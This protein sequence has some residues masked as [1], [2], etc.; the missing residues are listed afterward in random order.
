MNRVILTARQRPPV[1]AA[2]EALFQLASGAATPHLRSRRAATVGGCDRQALESAGEFAW[3]AECTFLVS[4]WDAM[5][6]ALAV[7]GFVR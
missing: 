6:S 7:F 1:R 3:R 4:V 2:L 5:C